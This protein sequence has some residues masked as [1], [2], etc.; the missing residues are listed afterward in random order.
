MKQTMAGGGGYDPRIGPF[1]WVLHNGYWIK[2][3]LKGAQW[4]TPPR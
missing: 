2:M 1:R 3:P 4:P